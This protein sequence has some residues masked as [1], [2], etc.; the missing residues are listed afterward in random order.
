MEWHITAGHA[1]LKNSGGNIFSSN[2][3]ELEYRKEGFLN[4][5]DDFVSKFFMNFG[6]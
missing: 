5:V 2:L 3:R 4:K 1:I 6:K